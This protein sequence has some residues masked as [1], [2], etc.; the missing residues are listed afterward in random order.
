M[1]SPLHPENEALRAV[2]APFF[3]VDLPADYGSPESEWQA[4]RKA[5][6]LFDTNYHAIFEISGPDR[7]RYLNAITTGDIKSLESGQGVLGLLLN[8]Q[9][10]ILAEIETYALPDKLLLLSHQEVRQRTVQTLDKFIIMDDCALADVTDQ[11]ASCAVEGPQSAKALAG[12]CGVSFDSLAEFS[13]LETRIAGAVCRIIRRSHFGF[14]GAEV[15]APR[16]KIGDVWRG[17][18]GTT[19]AHGGR[20][21]GYSALNALRLEAGIP[22]FGYDFDHK[23]IPHEAGLE[24]SHISYTKGCYTGQEIVERVRSRGHV[25]RRLALLQFFTENP[26]AVGTTLLAAGKEVG[27]VTSAATSPVTR[28]N[29]GFGYVRREHGAPGTYLEFAGGTAA[30]IEP[31]ARGFPSSL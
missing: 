7:A 24:I 2:L 27:H 9:G 14:P 12:A 25:N 18:L 23:V 17:L 15:L 19:K 10:H 4:A 8:A 13:H 29:I 11:F 20:P 30:I 16:G 1:Q 21:I 31:P 6:A 26:P 3:A 22:W 5:V 28:A